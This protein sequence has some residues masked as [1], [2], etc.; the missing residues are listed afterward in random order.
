MAG[1]FKDKKGTVFAGRETPGNRLEVTLLTSLTRKKKGRF[2][3]KTLKKR[4]KLDS[5]SGEKEEKQKTRLVDPSSKG[6][7]TG[8]SKLAKREKKDLLD[9]ES[10]WGEACRATMKK[11]KNT[12]SVYD[13]SLEI[14]LANLGR[15]RGKKPNYHT[16]RGNEGR[17]SECVRSLPRKRLLRTPRHWEEIE[18]VSVSGSTSQ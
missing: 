15:D 7:K 2:I 10:I 5:R 8:F 18:G 9:N 12:M 14:S 6:N 3:A 1:G 11:G 13:I 17:G 16:D 4:K